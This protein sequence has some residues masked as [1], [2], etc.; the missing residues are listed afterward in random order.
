M[1]VTSKHSTDD[2]NLV[3]ERRIYY[4]NN[5]KFLD[6]FNFSNVNLFT[7]EKIC[8]SIWKKNSKEKQ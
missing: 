8:T 2:Y 1:F 5:S 6:K 4:T 7:L 3:E